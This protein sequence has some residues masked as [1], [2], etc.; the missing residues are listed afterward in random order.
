M[1][2][3]M[4]RRSCKQCLRIGTSW[5]W[6]IF[7]PRPQAKKPSATLEHQPTASTLRTRIAI[8]PEQCSGSGSH[9][10]CRGLVRPHPRPLNRILVRLRGYF[11]NVSQAPPSFLYGSS[12]PHAPSQAFI[13][14]DDIWGAS[15]RVRV[16]QFNLSRFFHI[17]FIC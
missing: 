17:I 14:R 6:K 4:K 7:K 1:R 16:T 2:L 5:R 3:Q 13:L 12:H 8:H 11:Q 15:C 9:R 10:G